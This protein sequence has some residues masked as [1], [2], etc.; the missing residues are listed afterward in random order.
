MFNAN[1]RSVEETK[2]DSTL[3]RED[4]PDSSA[5]CSIFDS[6]RRKCILRR[7]AG[8]SVNENG[9]FGGGWLAQATQAEQLMPV[10]RVKG[11]AGVESLRRHSLH[12]V[13]RTINYRGLERTNFLITPLLLLFDIK[14]LAPIIFFQ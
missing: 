8:V 2:Y 5:S 6:Y 11:V 7:E 10:N 1:I 4:L 14:T 13:R 12:A 9:A 3:Q